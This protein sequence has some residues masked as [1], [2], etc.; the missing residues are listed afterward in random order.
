MKSAGGGLRISD[1]LFFQNEIREEGR[2]S[3]TNY[4][5]KVKRKMKSAGVW[6]ARV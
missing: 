2:E 4:F 5:F 3:V 6:G 1:K